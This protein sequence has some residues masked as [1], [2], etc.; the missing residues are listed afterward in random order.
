MENKGKLEEWMNRPGM[1]WKELIVHLDIIQSNSM[2]EVANKT[3]IRLSL[4]KAG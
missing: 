3:Q 2:V 1:L 4:H